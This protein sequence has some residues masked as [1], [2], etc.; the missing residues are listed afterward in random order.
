[1]NQWNGS[2]KPKIDRLV[3]LGNLAQKFQN[4]ADVHGIMFPTIFS[5]ADGQKIAQIVDV[6]NRINRSIL[7]VEG[8]TYGLKFTDGKIDIIAPIDMNPE[9][10]Q[11]DIVQGFGYHPLLW[12]AVIGV[13]VVGAIFAT[14]EL[15][16]SMA[17]NTTADTKKKIVDSAKEIAAMS[18]EMQAA[19]M[20]LMEENREEL[21]KAGLLDQLLGGGS[22]M[23]IAGAIAIGVILYAYTRSK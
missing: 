10:Y 4:W 15:V 8:G 9:E 20:K 23:M 17:D 22:G 7:K 6:Y 21:E 16:G 14:N 19:L 13:V 3:L 12:V 1:M 2:I 5:Q 18:P 11:A